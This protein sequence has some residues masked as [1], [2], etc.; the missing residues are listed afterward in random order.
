MSKKGWKDLGAMEK[1]AV[2][3]LSVA[4]LSLLVAALTDIYRRPAGE[5]RGGK[6]AWAAASFVSFAGPISYFVFGRKK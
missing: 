1:S 2:I 6:P 3:C 4:Q 5:I